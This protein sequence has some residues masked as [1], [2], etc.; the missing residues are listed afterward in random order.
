MI[1]SSQVSAQER[2]ASRPSEA[3]IREWQS[4]KYGMFIHF[5]LFSMLGGVW[6]GKQYS[7]NY[8]EQIQSDAHIPQNEYSALAAQFDP[9]RWD[10]E[11]IVRL[12]EQAGMKFIVLTAKHHDGFNMFATKQSTYNVVDGSPYKQDIVRSLAEACKRHGMPLGSTIQPSIGTSGTFP[13]KETIIRYQ[14][15]MKNSMRLN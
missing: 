14:P 7:G 10:A 4:R 9:T 11:A 12:A 5:G 1:V 2:A 13:K 6:K 8:S 15:H 3:T